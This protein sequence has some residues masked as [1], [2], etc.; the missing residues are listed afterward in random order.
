MDKIGIPSFTRVTT[1]AYGGFLFHS[2][3][4]LGLFRLCKN[5]AFAILL[6]FCANSLGRLFFG[7]LGIGRLLFGLLFDS[8]QK[9]TRQIGVRKNACARSDRSRAERCFFFANCWQGL[10]IGQDSKHPVGHTCTD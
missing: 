2:L 5:V 1:T 9:G 8:F 6:R 7:R 10:I 4:F 3:G